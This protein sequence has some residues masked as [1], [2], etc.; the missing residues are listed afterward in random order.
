MAV[1]R[2]RPAPYTAASAVV[3]IINRYRHRGLPTPVDK[4]VLARAGVADG[5]ISRTLYTIQVLDLI[6]ESGTP[7]QTFEALQLA[8]EAE[9]KKRMEEWLKEAY[10][11]VFSYVDPSKDDEIRVRDA[12]RS[13]QP[14]GQQGRMVALFM[15]L[16]AAAG[17][18]PEKPE[19]APRPAARVK[20]APQSPVAAFPTQRMRTAAKQTVAQ[21]FKN[22]PHYPTGLPE[23]LA[24]LLAKLPAE[25]DSW[26]KDER[27]KFLTTFTAVLDFCFEVEG[28]D[29]Q[30]KTA[31]Q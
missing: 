11:D 9:F 10:A 25:G 5:L 14:V 29:K 23:P 6:D 2:G 22:A 18:I 3:E 17:L 27:A 16:C 28:D 13:Y 7:T 21:Q 30:T 26:T 31:T 12:F 19:S 4:E 20:P 24:G 15:G 8:P 1:T